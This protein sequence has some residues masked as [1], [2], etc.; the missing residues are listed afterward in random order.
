MSSLSRISVK[1]AEQGLFGGEGRQFYY[2]VGREG[3]QQAA[4]RLGGCGAAR[5]ASRA[6]TRCSAA[7][8]APAAATG[9]SAAHAPQ[10]HARWHQLLPAAAPPAAAWHAA[11][12]G[13]RGGSS[14]AHT[15]AHRTAA[16]GRPA[17]VCRCVPFIRQAMQLEEIVSVRDMRS[18]I[19]E[20]FKEYK[21]VKDQRV[22]FEIGILSKQPVCPPAL[23]ARLEMKA[24]PRQRRHAAHCA[25]Q[26][27]R[28]LL[29]RPHWP[30]AWLQFPLPVDSARRLQQ[31]RS[32]TRPGA[33]PSMQL[34]RPARSAALTPPHTLTTPFQ[35]SNLHRLSTC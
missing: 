12:A 30:L 29:G 23:Q 25:I 7:P 35:P 3:R 1:A 16:P 20:K 13:A 18:V 34:R 5:S 17:Q 10:Q 32:S 33:T 15:L 6:R 8:A 2:E 24:G 27:A 22:R 21:D 31:V 11:P 28:C 14:S 9:P 4:A 26:H 19:K